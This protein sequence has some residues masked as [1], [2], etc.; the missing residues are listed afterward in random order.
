MYDSFIG[1]ANCSKCNKVH[2][3]EEQTKDYDC[4]LST[5]MLGDYID[6]ANTRYQYVFDW[7]CDNCKEDFKIHMFIHN[8][9]VIKIVNNIEESKMTIDDLVN[10][11]DEFQRKLDYKKCCEL[12]VGYN[13]KKY[14]VM[15][16]D[17]WSDIPKNI[18]DKIFALNKEWEIISV[19]KEVLVTSKDSR[20]YV[21][22][23]ILYKDNFVY[24]VKSIKGN[25]NRI[26][27]IT[28]DY[29]RGFGV[30]DYIMQHGCKRVNI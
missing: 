4:T 25:L 29:I 8:G 30:Y 28:E 16:T 27:R 14:N 20:L 3:F 23:D 22:H 10:I 11:E 21:L 5:F 19:G 26:L 15:N 6:K 18:G 1:K 9:Q 13:I 7:Y 2:E 12:G 17:T 24:D